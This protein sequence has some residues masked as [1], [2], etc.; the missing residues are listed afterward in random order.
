MTFEELTTFEVTIGGRTRL[1]QLKPL[2]YEQL[3]G[4]IRDRSRRQHDEAWW[5]RAELRLIVDIDGTEIDDNELDALLADADAAARVIGAREQ[6]YTWLV[7]QGR[8][9]ATC[10]E[11]G[12]AKELDLGAYVL[13]LNMR[14]WPVLD[15]LLLATPGLATPEP[16]EV[17]DPYGERPVALRGLAPRPA[18]PPRAARIDFEL[19]SARCGFSE[20]K[21]PVAGTIGDIDPERE[22]DAWRKYVPVG[23]PQPADYVAWTYDEA[24]FRAALRVMI[25]TTEL[26]DHNG[27]TLPL[28]PPRFT[29]MWLADVQFLDALYTATHELPAAAT[30]AVRCSQGHAFL[31]VR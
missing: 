16:P 7:E 22:G 31:P 5:L 30:A 23:R 12:N 26:R 3:P 15:G 2:R 28:E 14:P 13:L 4:Y 20:S 9:R 24:W 10:P 18:Q 29:W 8:V 1:V 27:N 25:A 17:R 11:C 6:L 21:D 19:P